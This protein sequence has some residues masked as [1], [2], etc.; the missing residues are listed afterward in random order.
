[1][2]DYILVQA[3]TGSQRLK[4]KI[5]LKIQGK[6]ILE[7]LISRLKKCKNIH[8]LIIV[9]TKKSRDDIIVKICKKIKLITFR[10]SENNLINRYYK[11]A[12]IL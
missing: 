1:M 3:R 2:N 9:T 8:N 4:N 5:L 10:G 12:K 7:I 6:T 11:C